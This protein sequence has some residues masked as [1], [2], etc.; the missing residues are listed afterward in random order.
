MK[1]TQIDSTR[2][3]QNALQPP[4]HVETLTDAE[5]RRFRMC[6]YGATWC[7]CFAEVMMENSAILILFM[8]LLKSSASMQMLSTSM[9]GLVSMLLMFFAAGLANRF[10]AKRAIDLAVGFEMLSCLLIASAPF[11][12]FAYATY[13]VL[14]GCFLFCV[15]RPIWTASW[16][17]VMGDI[18]LPEERGPFLGFMRFSYYSITG[19]AFFL[20]GYAMGKESPIWIP[21]LVIAATGILALGRAFFI[22]KIRLGERNAEGFRILQSLKIAVKN[23]KLVSFSIYVA[24]MYLAFAP[25]LPL[26]IIYMKQHLSWGDGLV[27][28]LSTVGIAGSISGFILYGKLQKILGMKRLQLFTHFLYLAIP[29]A[30]AIFGKN[31]SALETTC[32]WNLGP[33]LLSEPILVYLLAALTFAACF[34]VAL[35]GCIVSQETLALARPGNVAMATAFN[36]TYVM[37]G[38]AVGR[39]GMALVLGSGCLSAAWVKWDMTFSCYQTLF[40]LCAAIAAFALFLL[41]SLPSM[42]PERDDWYQPE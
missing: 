29:L 32:E 22:H 21:Q 26:T 13:V 8:T 5:R 20:I 34:A 9:N 16:Y 3:A 28:I 27:Q 19:V 12:G 1:E 24:M 41:P 35:F 10:G 38:T 17:V 30:L 14:V 39:S 2:N 7:G 11:W 23:E 37:I 40:F 6:A 18:L 33:I 42:I 25:V 4:S 15:S 36:Q 31:F